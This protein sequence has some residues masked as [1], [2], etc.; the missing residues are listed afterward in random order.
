MHICFEVI[1]YSNVMQCLL[2]G[3]MGNLVVHAQCGILALPTVDQQSGAPNVK[4]L[5]HYIQ[6]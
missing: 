2:T 5:L 4:A 3:F 6:L 1:I